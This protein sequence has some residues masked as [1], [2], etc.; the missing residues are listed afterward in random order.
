MD[1]PIDVAQ[2]A[3]GR[4]AE[5]AIRLGREHQR[6]MCAELGAELWIVSEHLRVA[7]LEQRNQVRSRISKL[8]REVEKICAV[9]HYS[10]LPG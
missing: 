3:L 1:D 7:N 8:L 6:P 4:V 5:I 10:N 2:I 9:S